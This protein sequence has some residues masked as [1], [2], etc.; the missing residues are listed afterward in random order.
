[1]RRILLVLAVLALAAAA[2]LLSPRATHHPP[3]AAPAGTTPIAAVPLAPSQ[4]THPEI[5][6]RRPEFLTEHFAKHGAELNARDEAAYLEMAQS[7]RDRPAG[8]MV[9]EAK[10]WDG[11]ITR[12]DR[13]TGA[14]LAFNADLTIRTL[15]RP[16]NGE[17]YFRRQLEQAH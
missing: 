14:F 11:V 17:E 9:L 12:F 8:G 5:G 2:V 10:R 1:M 15:F 4:V 3:P 16:N 13:A 6:F 7:L